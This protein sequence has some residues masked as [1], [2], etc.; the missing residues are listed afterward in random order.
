LISAAASYA[1]MSGGSSSESV[2]GAYGNSS[3]TL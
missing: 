3:V 2:T 1:F